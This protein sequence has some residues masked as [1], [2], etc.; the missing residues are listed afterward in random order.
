VDFK[1][2]YQVWSLR[3]PTPCHLVQLAAGLLAYAGRALENVQVLLTAHRLSEPMRGLGL[4]A[5]SD[6]CLPAMPTLAAFL[7]LAIW[8]LVM[9]A[10]LALKGMA[11]WNLEVVPTWRLEVAVTTRKGDAVEVA[12]AEALTEVATEA[13]VL[14]RTSTLAWTCRTPPLMRETAGSL[15]T[16]PCH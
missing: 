10:T 9:A 6:K 11:T 15:T 16:A 5:A 12:A 8:Q 1:E 7:Q 2:Q 3:P 4:S 14:C 13:A